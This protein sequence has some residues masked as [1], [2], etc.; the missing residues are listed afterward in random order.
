MGTR[1]RKNTLI[2]F[3]PL[4]G[5]HGPPRPKALLGVFCLRAVLGPHPELL[6]L[7]A[8]EANRGF[9]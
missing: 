1:T 3:V 2:G 8:I 5:L 6:G 9:H 4:L 7:E